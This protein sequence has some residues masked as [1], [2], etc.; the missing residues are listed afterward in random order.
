M[1]LVCITPPREDSYDTRCCWAKDV[2]VL[3]RE[4]VGLV[5]GPVFSDLFRE[6]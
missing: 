1:L 2:L 5:L 4:S 6:R 3:N